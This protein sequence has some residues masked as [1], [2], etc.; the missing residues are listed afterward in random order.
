[1][2]FTHMWINAVAEK[3][4]WGNI[5]CVNVADYQLSVN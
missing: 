3:W 5:N 4:V 1:M 2:A